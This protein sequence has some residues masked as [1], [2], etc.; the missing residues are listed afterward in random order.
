MS[1]IAIIN[2]E[3]GGRRFTSPSRAREYVRRGR[4][5]LERGK[6]RFLG[7]TQEFLARR[8]DA[9]AEAEFNRNR[10]G[11]IFWNGSDPNPLAMHRPAEVRS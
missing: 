3:P 11:I 2:P 1:A 7:P 4:A 9:E 8:R 5:V 10:S 6:L